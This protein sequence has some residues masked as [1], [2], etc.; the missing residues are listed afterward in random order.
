MLSFQVKYVG[1]NVV[2][3]ACRTKEVHTVRQAAK[4]LDPNSFV[5]ILDS[6]EVAGEGF[7]HL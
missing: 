6:N 1:R 7:R 2:M 3:C 4:K 5:I